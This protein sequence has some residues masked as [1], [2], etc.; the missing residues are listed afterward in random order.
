[1]KAVSMCGRLWIFCQRLKDLDLGV[2]LTR[3]N[4][5]HQ[6]KGRWKYRKSTMNFGKV[7]AGGV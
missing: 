3:D 4:G 1:M 7:D 6:Q 2:N 5:F